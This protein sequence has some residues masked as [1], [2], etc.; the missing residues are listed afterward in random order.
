MC[1]WSPVCL[2]HTVM[3]TYPPVH[4]LWLQYLLVSASSWI[5]SVVIALQHLYLMSNEREWTPPKFCGV[6]LTEL[7]V[8]HSHYG[9]NPLLHS[10]SNLLSLSDK[11][12]SSQPLSK[13]SSYSVTF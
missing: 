9:N 8:M 7:P 6:I 2:H 12:A 11:N 1:G 4:C 13:V 10:S 3:S 5:A